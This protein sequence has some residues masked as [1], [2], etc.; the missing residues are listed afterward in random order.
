ML[1]ETIAIK[2]KKGLNIPLKGVPHRLLP[3]LPKPQKISLNLESFPEIRFSLLVEEGS[4]VKIGTPLVENKKI[5]GQYF[6][7]P[8]CGRIAEIWRGERRALTDIVIDVAEE[9]E[10]QKWTPPPLSSSK[11]EIIDYLLQTG[12]FAH[13]RARPFNQI[14]HP[15]I[16]PRDIFVKALE[17]LP[18]VPPS[19]MQVEGNEEHFRTGL[20]TLK[21]L[22]TGSVFLVFSN[23]TH[24]IA[25]KEAQNVVRISMEG[26][27]PAGDASVHI[28]HISPI[29]HAEDVVWTL[30]AQDVVILGKMMN[31]GRYEVDRV[32]GIGGEGISEEKRGFM[33]ARMG[34][35][36]SALVDKNHSSRLVSG[37]L[38]TGSEVSFSQ[39]MKFDHFALSTILENS[40]R[41][42]FHFL[43]L[44]IQKFSMHRTYYTGI[45][46]NSCFGYS[47]S[48]NQH[49]E[50]RPF[51]DGS[52]YEKVMPMKIPVMPLIRAILAED[53]E[54]AEE[55]GFLEIVPE[56]LALSA[57]ICPSK[58]E[59]PDI[60]RKGI[61][62]FSKEA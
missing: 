2:I 22:T 37:D 5:P 16:V 21:K 7:S 20:E 14:A 3:S 45:K 36:I 27:H 9:E 58:I 43:R 59:M 33:K 35:P 11:E 1:N 34:I 51:I 42:P 25:F 54:L 47:F 61:K 57:F 28:H 40:S 49:G 10:Y 60:V 46:K 56:D 6:V 31:E 13:I 32:I 41:E 30:N 12:L 23:Q 39:F 48:T 53:F 29:K 15:R 62:I 55:L 50:E 52:I 44:G 24:Q 26:P 38:L 4:F 17:T 19:E 18:F 8:A